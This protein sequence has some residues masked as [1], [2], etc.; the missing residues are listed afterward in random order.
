MQIDVLRSRC[1]NP[2]VFSNKQ[3]TDPPGAQNREERKP[4]RGTKSNGIARFITLWP[5]VGAIDVADL[6]DELAESSQD[7][8]LDDTNLTADV[9]HGENNGLLLLG[10]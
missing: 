8:S 9:G 2:P 10:L 4:C 3:D 1:A 7:T 5:K 6:D